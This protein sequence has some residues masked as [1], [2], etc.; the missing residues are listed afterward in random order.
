MITV[1]LPRGVTLTRGIALVPRA[2]VHRPV[3]PRHD[4]VDDSGVD[5]VDRDDDGSG[6][7]FMRGS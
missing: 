2:S 6:E 7:A 3:L 1:A 4:K 5:D